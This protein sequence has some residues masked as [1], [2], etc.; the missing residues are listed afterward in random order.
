VNSK[1]ANGG[2]SAEVGEVVSC[3]SDVGGDWD[4]ERF[5]ERELGLRGNGQMVLSEAMEAASSHDGALGS[6]CPQEDEVEP[7]SG[8]QVTDFLDLCER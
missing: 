3:D 2:S 7:K 8:C 5:S 1:P 4:W 6:A